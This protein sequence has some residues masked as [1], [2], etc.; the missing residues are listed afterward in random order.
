MHVVSTLTLKMKQESK[1]KRP[2]HQIFFKS[3]ISSIVLDVWSD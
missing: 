2:T 1:E 3:L